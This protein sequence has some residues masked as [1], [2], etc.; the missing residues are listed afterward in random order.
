MGPM[1]HEMMY[2]DD[3]DIINDILDTDRKSVV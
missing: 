1:N 2:M 3:Y